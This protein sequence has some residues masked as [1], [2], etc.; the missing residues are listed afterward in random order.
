M[1]ILGDISTPATAKK[2]RILVVF[3]NYGG[4]A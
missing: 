1:N 2:L 4:C 3:A